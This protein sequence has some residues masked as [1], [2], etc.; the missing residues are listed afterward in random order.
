MA[1]NEK[2]LAVITQ[3]R[4]E[5]DRVLGEQDLALIRAWV[6]AWDELAGQFEAALADLYMQAVDGRV[7]GTLA[8]RNLRLLEALSQA[9]D[10]L[11]QLSNDAVVSATAAAQQVIL[12]SIQSNLD[13]VI[14]QMPEDHVASLVRNWTR[15]NADALDAIVARTAERIQSQFWPLSDDA[16]K[17]MKT[18]LVRGIAVGDNPRRVAKDM[19]RRAE[20]DFNGGLNRAMVIARTEILDAHRAA[21]KAAE[22]G[23]ADVLKGWIWIAT[24]DTKT[25][26]S[27]I[28]MHGT[29]HPL[30]DDGPLDHHQG[31]C[32]RAPLTKSWKDLGFDIEEPPSII[33]DAEEWF[34]GLTPDAQ[35]RIMGPTRLELLQSGDIKLKDLSTLRRTDGWRDARYVTPVRDLRKL[36]G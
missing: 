20:R 2:A 34:N 15:V 18:S 25:C 28:G 35:L 30:A 11:A 29:E 9:A 12:D 31:R 19:V 16:V 22:A 27:C 21:A 8:S 17:A 10:K 14:A 5:L 23:N 1:Y 3:R 36:G 24:L 4:A 32:D 13:A 7:K 33:P 6:E 26:P